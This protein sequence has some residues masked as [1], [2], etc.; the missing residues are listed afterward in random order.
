MGIRRRV[1]SARAW[2][3]LAVMAGASAFGVAAVETRLRPAAPVAE[4]RAPPDHGEVAVIGPPGPGT[5]PAAGPAPAA[6]PAAPLGLRAMMAGRAGE[7]ARLVWTGGGVPP[8][9]R[10][11]PGPDGRPV[12]GGDRE[13]PGPVR[14]REPIEPPVLP[15]D[16]WREWLLSITLN[17][18]PVSDGALVLRG[19][20][21][22]WAARVADLRAWRVRLDQSRITT[23]D[24]EPFYP[25]EALPGLEQ[26][27]DERRLALEL[28]L[29]PERFAA[30][31]LGARRRDHLE[32][33]ADRGGYF[34]YDIV[35]LGG[36]GV[37]SRLDALLELG[38]FDEA[39]V[40]ITNFRAGDIT[41]DERELVRLDTTFIKDFPGRRASLVVGDSLTVGGALGRPVR[42]A[43]LQWQSNFATDPSFITF[44]LPAIGGLAEQPSTA[45]VFLDNTRRVVEEI[46]PGPFE[47]DSLPVVTGAGELQLRVT[48]L[49]GREQVISQSFYVSPRLLRTGLSEFSYELG[50]EREAFS[51][52]SFGYDDPFASATHRYGISDALAAEGRLEAGWGR[53]AAGAG[54]S[55]LLG[56]FGLVSGGVIA[57][58]DRDAGAG[59]AAFADYEYRARRFDFG[60][61]T[62]Y[63][64]A[65]FRQLGSGEGAPPARVDQASFGLTLHPWG[66]LGTL[67]VN[68]KARNGP[69]RRAASANYSV[70]LGPGTLL[71]NALRTLEPGDELAL[72]ASFSLPLGA[73]R[74]VSSS[75]VWRDDAARGRAQYRQDKGS[76]DLGLSYRLAS[77]VGER[78]RTVDASVRYDAEVASG[79]L[80][81]DRFEGATGVRANLAGSLSYI[82]GELRPSRR[83]GRAFGLVALPGHPDVTVYLENREV[84]RTDDEG[85]LL[86]PRLKPYQKNRVRI[87][88]EDLPLS[89]ELDEEEKVAVP[90]ARAGVAI[91]FD[92]AVRRTALAT[93]EDADGAP[94]P[95]GLVLESEDG[96]LG[97]QV[98]K[99]G[100][101]YVEATAAGPAVL[102]SAGDQPAFRCALPA[103]P[104]EP[105]ARLGTLRCEAVP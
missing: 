64:D 6:P 15:G 79:R 30:T 91:P 22:Q 60:L 59:L 57:S 32:P 5:V 19:P 25:L 26:T 78:A 24:G 28:V 44:P 20:D 12:I 54:G 93:L 63:A 95:A 56:T 65:D 98:A 35:Y 104:E 105:M 34:D 8:G 7:A 90:F 72:T 1:R 36:E 82:D 11:P 86:L 84:G 68:T 52:D 94:L 77:E 4:R 62:A 101:A 3:L 40:L 100:L 71:L 76:S 29:P 48:D 75:A 66:R 83:L 46:P 67:L 96:A 92:V 80:D 17:G 99:D 37:R 9:F 43:G 45:E 51:R 21:G 39:G 55:L 103:L 53:Q 73:S 50:F 85:Y 10:P 13:A 27:F 49:L 42:F 47:I 81:V 2:L 87:R 41:R 102:T 16:E 69:D 74:T 23:F 31:T 14:R 89:A 38:A 88:A 70:S 18:E 61:R 97:A 33:R 58:H